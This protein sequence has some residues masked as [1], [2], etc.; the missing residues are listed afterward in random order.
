M[1]TT[2]SPAGKIMWH[3][4]FCA[5]FT[6][7][8]KIIYSSIPGEASEE[9]NSWL[10]WVLLCVCTEIS[11]SIY[12]MDGQFLVYNEKC[13]NYGSIA[14]FGNDFT[15]MR[16]WIFLEH[17]MLLCFKETSILQSLS[18]VFFSLWER[19]SRQTLPLKQFFRLTTCWVSKAWVTIWILENR[20]ANFSVV[21]REG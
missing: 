18:N 4:T 19:K 7:W 17:I 21:E 16:S 1:Q 13:C 6:S 20:V 8:N 5:W 2:V 3:L 14:V 11:L 9:F 15:Y 12:F 10:C